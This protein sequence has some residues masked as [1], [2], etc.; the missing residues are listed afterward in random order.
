MLDS[1][2]LVAAIYASCAIPVM[3]QPLDY[4]GFRLI[5]G[6]VKDRPALAAAQSDERIFFHHIASKSSWRKKED[7]SIQIPKRDNLASLAIYDLPRSGPLKLEV[8]QEAYQ[9]AYFATRR[10]LN[11]ELIDSNVSVAG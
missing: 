11:M 10:A 1:G 8:G 7:P 2:D 5:D 3:F 4:Q 6:G 9:R